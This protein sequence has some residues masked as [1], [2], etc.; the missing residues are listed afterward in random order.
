MDILPFL[1]CHALNKGCRFGLVNAFAYTKGLFTHTQ[2]KTK[3]LL[4]SV[5]KVL[6]FHYRNNPIEG[7]LSTFNSAKF[8]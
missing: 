6:L 4:E 3:C 1:I 2:K 8:E 7:L 5:T